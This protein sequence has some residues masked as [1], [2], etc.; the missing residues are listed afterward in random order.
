VLYSNSNFLF[1]GWPL[2]ANALRAVIL[3]EI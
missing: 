3:T 1:S 2:G